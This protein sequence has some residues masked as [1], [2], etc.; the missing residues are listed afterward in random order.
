[1]QAAKIQLELVGFVDDGA[2]KEA[3]ERARKLARENSN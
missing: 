2:C 1:M 3:V